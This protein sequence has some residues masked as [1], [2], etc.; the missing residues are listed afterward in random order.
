[1][2]IIRWGICGVTI[3]DLQV[4][5][6]ADG[7]TLLWT[8]SLTIRLMDSPRPANLITDTWRPIVVMFLRLTAGTSSIGGGARDTRMTFLSSTR[9]CREHRRRRLLRSWP[10]QFPS[11]SGVIWEELQPSRKRIFP[12]PITIGSVMKG[13]MNW[14]LTLTS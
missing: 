1:M 4:L 13:V 3:Q 10:L 11:S 2:R 9:R 12:G 8:V 6:R 7:P 5:T 14:A